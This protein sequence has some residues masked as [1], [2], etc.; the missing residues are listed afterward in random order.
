MDETSG[1]EKRYTLATRDVDLTA[2]IVTGLTVVAGIVW[3]CLTDD[4][5]LLIIPLL[6]LA[7]CL[8]LLISLL[9]RFVTEPKN[10]I[11]ATRRG[12]YLCYRNKNEVFIDYNEIV[13]V[14][15]AGITNK[16]GR[17][18]I[19]TADNEYRSIRTKE[20]DDELLGR[21]NRLLA[22]ADKED[23]LIRISR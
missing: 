21:I 11:Q 3:A 18:V 19:V 20:L 1:S 9:Y 13:A 4:R 7:A 10:A 8:V 14:S 17:I 2:L 5:R 15:R 22:A 6:L 16:Y 12:I 23:F